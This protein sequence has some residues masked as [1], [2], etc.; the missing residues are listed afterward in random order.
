MLATARGRTRLTYCLF[1]FLF[2][3]PKSISPRTADGTEPRSP[4]K[5]SPGRHLGELGG[6]T[7]GGL[8]VGL[9]CFLLFTKL[10]SRRSKCLYCFP[11]VETPGYMFGLVL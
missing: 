6:F 8:G 9:V 4:L 5:I 10:L 7:V 3:P 1:S 11:P 2:L